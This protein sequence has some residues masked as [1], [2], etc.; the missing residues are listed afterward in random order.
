MVDRQTF[1]LRA[2]SSI[3][4]A[5]TS[6]AALLTTEP[7]SWVIEE[8]FGE[9][10]IGGRPS[11][12]AARSLPHLGKMRQRRRNL[13]VRTDWGSRRDL[14][15]DVCHCRSLLVALVCHDGVIGPVEGGTRPKSPPLSAGPQFRSVR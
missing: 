10:F 7:G 14:P 8:P 12:P 5:P 6:W 4:P 13:R 2:G 1:N 11:G 15:V 3:L 9:P